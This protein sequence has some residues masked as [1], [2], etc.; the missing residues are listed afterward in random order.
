MAT[1][2]AE[3]STRAE[4]NPAVR[5]SS[6]NQEIEPAYSL[7]TNSTASAEAMDSSRQ[8][9]SPDQQEE[10]RNL[11]KSLHET[12]LQHRRMSN[13][14]FEPVSLPVSRVSPRPIVGDV[15]ASSDQFLAALSI[16]ATDST[17]VPSNDSINQNSQTSRDAMPSPRPQSRSSLSASSLQS[18]PLTPAASG[19]RES[20][21]HGTGHVA[22]SRHDPVEITPHP[23][24]PQRFPDDDSSSVATSA[25]TSMPS[26][27]RG[28]ISTP[29]SE[30]STANHDLP[31]RSP[32]FSPGP[33]GGSFPPSRDQSPG[34]PGT[35]TPPTSY[36]RPFTP[37]GD[38]NDPYARSRRDPQKKGFEGIEPRFVF[39]A[40]VGKREHGSSSSL[41]LAGN[42]DPK[43]QPGHKRDEETAGALGHKHQ[44]SM[45]DLKR[46]LRIGGHKRAHSPAPS[47][48][49]SMSRNGTRTPP[50]HHAPPSTVPFAEDHGL[51]SK[52][53]KFG[54]VLGSGAGG[55][56]R[57]MKRSSDGVT[58]AVKQFRE[59]HP[60]ESERDYAKKVTAEFCIGST[61]HH[62]NIIETLD[63]VHEKGHWYEVMEYA[64]F[65]LFAIVMTGKMSRE[66][67]T[68]S[69]LQIFSGVTYLH[70]LGLA[71]RDLK[72]DNVVVNEH[73]IMKLIDFG[74]AT[75]FRYPFENDIVLASGVVG[76]DPYL[77]PEVYDLSRY[78]PQPTDIWSLAIIYACMSLRRF[79][80]KAPR[81]SDNSYKLFVSAPTPGTPS[82]E[83]GGR[84]SS[85]R[86]KTVFDGSP[87]VVPQQQQQPQQQ[88]PQAPPQSEQ[89]SRQQTSD[90]SATK[91]SHHHHHHHHTERS[92]SNA[93][94]LE[95][96]MAQP[97]QPNAQVA[98]TGEGAVAQLKPESIR[99]P[100]RLL[101]LLP[102]ESRYIM[103]RMLDTNPKTRATLEDVLEDPWVR[104]T[105]ICSQVEGGKVW[106]AEGH[107]HT[108]EPGTAVTPQPSRK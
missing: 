4:V 87:A 6:V 37:V 16:R 68:C 49:P 69:F 58:F 67:I 100:W 64:P 55:S 98:A 12:R 22:R 42:N 96:S 70:S 74:S 31:R 84:R 101:R 106:R 2:K 99:G 25:A 26:G 5:F 9:I 14:A 39:N 11:S 27:E 30:Q 38:A 97:D 57:L 77:A 51:Q 80:W 89:P 72:L 48:K 107:E 36:T 90:T 35:S 44:G 13:F 108:L 83:G 7:Q 32:R 54:K 29:I 20:D 23:S 76:S 34:R 105:P 66:E 62:G 85:E 75:V 46:F 52:Y 15:P 92:E 95:A 18:P 82:A 102:R 65:D 103:S 47:S 71:H 91:H 93:S 81:L 53:G 79:P 3:K 60:Y 104:N 43:V 61:L 50:S 73:G 24:V 88:Q 17:Q 41:P 33:Q 19:S 1:S 78:D 28:F 40:R 8:P 59:R 94:A 56:V 45:S 21:S 86:P 10:L 63:I